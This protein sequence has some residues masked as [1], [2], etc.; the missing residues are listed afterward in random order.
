MDLIP[1]SIPM[2][3]EKGIGCEE[4]K[5]SALNGKDKEF[6]EK[7]ENCNALEVCQNIYN[8]QNGRESSI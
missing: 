4:I 7:F 5:L 6:F 8:V 2:I 1:Y 3:Y